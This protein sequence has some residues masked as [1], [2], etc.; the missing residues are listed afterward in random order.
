MLRLEQLELFVSAIGDRLTQTLQFTK[1]APLPEKPNNVELRSGRD[2]ELEA[3]ARKLLHSLGA[4]GLASGVKVDWSRRLRTAAGRADYHRKLITLN[5]RLHEHGDGEIDRTL[6]HE[7]AHLLAH[8]RAGR[9]RISA[10]GPEWRRACADL[11]IANEK[12]C[13]TLP[14]PTRRRVRPF[15][16]R[17]PNCAAD[18]PR[19][20]RIKRA[21]ACLACCRRYNRG[22]FDQQFQLR[23]V[24][25]IPKA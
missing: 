9:R 18:F 7:L 12:R 4:K 17:C 8:F 5:P 2:A 16:Y 3:H 13:H 14:F 23:L 19:T 10:H 6:R 22:Q 25:T 15:L 24:R 20:R 21:L 1:S 11:G